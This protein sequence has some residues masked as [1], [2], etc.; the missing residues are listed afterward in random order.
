M[1]TA[2]IPSNSENPIREYYEAITAGKIAASKKVI[3]VYQH[4]VDKLDHDGKDGYYYDASKA[5]RVITFIGKF[6]HPSKG[7]AARRPL[8]LEL[9]QKALLSAMFGFVTDDGLREYK[10]VYLIVGR[11]NGKS[12]LASAVALYLLLKDGEAGPEIYSAA[13]KA[14]QAKV[15]WSESCKMIHKSPALNKR[16]KTLVGSI[17]VDYNDGVFRPLSRDSHSLD[18]LNIS[19][20]CCDEIHAWTDM[21]MFDVLRD[22]MSAREQPLMF[23]T[24]TAGTVRDSVYD[25]KYDEM[26]RIINGYA[27]GSYT[28]E[29]TLP[30]VYELDDKQ[31][32]WNPA[33]W[34]KANP[35]LGSIK[36]KEDLAEKVAKAK[37]DPMRRKNLLT[38]DFDV[39]QSS[40]V[41]YFELEDLCRDTHDI[42]VLKPDYCIGGIDLS[43]RVDLTA[44]VA[45]YQIPDD[46]VIYVE[47]MFWM[48]EDTLE[49][50]KRD[51]VPY[52]T[53][54]DK[55]YI[56]LCPGNIIDDDMV[57]DWYDELR[58]EHD[59]FLYRCGYDRYSATHLIQEMT[60]RF[61]DKVM[62]PIA[63]GVKTLSGPME[64]S[65]ALLQQHKIN[66]GANPVMDWCL[67]NTEAKADT[68]GN[69]QP[70]K[71]RQ[72]NKRIDGYAALLDALTVYLD[73]IEAYQARIS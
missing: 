6:I 67:L 48:P 60:R 50:H 58:R 16:C 17:R 66:Y 9:W 29:R 27:D 53:W 57:A 4:L 35:G 12:T 31:E 54:I 71:D 40:T 69:I 38:K 36:S 49:Q 28:D 56:R 46:P 7:K 22:G 70:Y 62:V 43:R 8:Q 55:G 45:L 23:V 68:N 3:A 25:S 59:L 24:S 5:E 26:T 32:M 41:S 30:I 2:S 21:N 64:T 18:G 73:N 11:K 42:D 63:Q 37:A 52:Q 51:N 39:I 47:S 13:T 20:C 44:A 19:G 10:E 15:I 34:Q 14:E 72:L 61:G 65:K 1:M 33:K